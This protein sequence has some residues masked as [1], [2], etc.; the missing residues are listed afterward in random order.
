MG[1][2]AIYAHLR[3][4]NARSKKIMM[5]N[6]RHETDWFKFASKSTRFE[7]LGHRSGDKQFPYFAVYVN[8]TSGLRPEWVKTRYFF[9]ERE[10]INIIPISQN[11]LF[12]ELL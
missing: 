10:M 3:A 5:S 4:A 6:T 2:N 1:F 8:V 7:Y 12:V 9:E 11:Q